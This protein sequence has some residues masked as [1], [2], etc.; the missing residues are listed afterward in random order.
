[1]K[2]VLFVKNVKM[3]IV[4]MKMF[5]NLFLNKNVFR[6]KCRIVLL[7]NV[8]HVKK[9]IVVE[10]VRKIMLYRKDKIIWRIQI[11]V[12]KGLVIVEL[13][14]VMFVFNVKRITILRKESVIITMGLRFY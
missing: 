9:D 14:I 4:Y 8:N 5:Q 6:I 12:Y 7:K 13:V 11:S 10:S 1:M 2:K 3:V